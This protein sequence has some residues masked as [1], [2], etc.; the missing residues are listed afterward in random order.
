MRHVRWAPS[1]VRCFDLHANISLYLLR[2]VRVRRSACR[3]NM[4]AREVSV[5]RRRQCVALASK[6]SNGETA[7]RSSPAAAALGNWQPCQ[8]LCKSALRCSGISR[9]SASLGADRHETRIS[10]E[11]AFHARKSA[12]LPSNRRNGSNFSNAGASSTITHSGFAIAR[13]PH[14]CERYSLKFSLH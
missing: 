5:Q 9:I 7:A 8:M 2:L 14:G 4:V 11:S 3:L 10:P 12:S 6:P 1:G 13:R